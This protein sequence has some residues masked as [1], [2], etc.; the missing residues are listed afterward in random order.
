MKT[1]KR[2]TPPSKSA[3][4]R[5]NPA[6]PRASIHPSIPRWRAKKRG[7]ALDDS[8]LDSEG[9]TSS[10]EPT[11]GAIPSV[12]GESRSDL[13]KDERWFT[14]DN[15]RLYCLQQAALAALA[16]EKDTDSKGGKGKGAKGGPF[17]NGG[18]VNDG[19]NNV[20]ILCLCREVFLKDRLKELRKFRTETN[21]WTVVIGML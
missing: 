9:G 19:M 14:F 17:S 1:P 11:D 12:W 2:F 4:P 16:S 18:G 6:T 3:T 10:P 7:A 5:A 13:E 15:R 8:N 21:G 20:K